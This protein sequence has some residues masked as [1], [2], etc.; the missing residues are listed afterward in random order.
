MTKADLFCHLI[1]ISLSLTYT[2]THTHASYKP[3]HTHLINL[4]TLVLQTKRLTCP[5]PPQPPRAA[6]CQLYRA[7]CFLLLPHNPSVFQQQEIKG[8]WRGTRAPRLFDLCEPLSLMKIST[9]LRT[10]GAA[11]R[12]V[13][14]SPHK[15]TSELCKS[16]AGDWP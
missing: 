10:T 8:V 13:T 14:C 3:L 15:Q 6:T 1:S 2:H 7:S 12:G 4:V 11:D 9:A 5:H 16:A